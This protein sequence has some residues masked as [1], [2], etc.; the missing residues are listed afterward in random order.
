[1]MKSVTRFN[2]NRFWPR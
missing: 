2:D 1:M